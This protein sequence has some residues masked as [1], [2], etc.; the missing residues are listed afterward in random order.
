MGSTMKIAQTFDKFCED[1]DSWYSSSD[2]KLIGNSELLAV[3]RVL[4]NG[5]GLEVGVSSGFFASALGIR[6]GIDP[7]EKC[8]MK[9]RDRGVETILGVGES[10]PFE[11]ESLDFVL[12]AASLCFLKDPVAALGEAHRV[13]RPGGSVVLCFIPKESS[14][15]KLYIKKKK[16]G[17]RFYEHATFFTNG[18]VEDLLLR[19]GFKL[20]RGCCTL[21]Q[22]PDEV[23]K[24]E[25]P[26][27]GSHESAG[28]CCV[29]ADKV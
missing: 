25:N 1:Y 2:G 15:G 8:L 22:K 5:K 11:N 13:L 23:S 19:T 26:V 16:S 20:E 27:D 9:A 3:K 24:V 29:R 12:Y 17:R 21:F 10:L 14:W 4:P 28:F 7:S 18:E 6:F